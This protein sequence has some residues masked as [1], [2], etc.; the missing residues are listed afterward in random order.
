[1]TDDGHPRPFR[2]GSHL[3][4][5][6]LTSLTV[7]L[8]LVPPSVRAAL[9]YERWAVLKGE[10]WRLLGASLVHASVAH[11]LWNLAGL[12][13]VW[14]A[15]GPRLSGLAWTAAGLA[16]ALGSMLGVLAFHPEVRFVAGLSGVL[17]GLLVAGS[18]AEIRKRVRVGWIVLVVVAL[19]IA[20]EQAGGS[21]AA[22]AALGGEVAAH[23]HLYGALTG[24]LVGLALPAADGERRS[25]PG[26]VPSLP[27][28]RRTGDGPRPEA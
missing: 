24:V 23:T 28:S 14:I 2:P 22:A 19:K 1:M 10:V 17:H 16:C 13:M 15:F 12:A 20:W 25:P 4:F 27:G 11:L 18:L 5:I 3:F 26:P 21:S 6:G 9:A 8:A 7:A